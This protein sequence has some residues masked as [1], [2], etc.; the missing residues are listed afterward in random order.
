DVNTAEDLG[1]IMLH[2]SETEARKYLK[3]IKLKVKS[4]HGSERLDVSREVSV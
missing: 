1:E 2:G 3:K 4:N